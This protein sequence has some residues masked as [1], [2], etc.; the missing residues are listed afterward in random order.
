ML[1]T[2]CLRIAIQDSYKLCAIGFDMVSARSSTG[3][4][5]LRVNERDLL[6]RRL[7]T[8]TRVR[9][10]AIAASMSPCRSFLKSPM[11]GSYLA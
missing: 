3:H 7:S 6:M 4:Y 5:Q 8:A 10:R 1:G 9:S 11:E 2:I